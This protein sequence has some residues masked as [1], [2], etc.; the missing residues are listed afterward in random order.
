M[1]YILLTKSYKSVILT[2]V[3][4]PSFSGM[5]LYILSL[6][7]GITLLRFFVGPSFAQTTT[8]QPIYGGGQT[9][10]ES[11]DLLVDKKIK[12]PTQAGQF[13]DNL[14]GDSPRYGLDQEII[15]NIDVKNTGNNTIK[16]ITVQDV[17]P[18]QY[19]V[20]TDRIGKF[21]HKTKLFTYTIAELKKDE[22]KRVSIKARSVKAEQFPWGENVVCLVNQALTFTSRTKNNPS[23]DNS[24]FC[25]QRQGPTRQEVIPSPTIPPQTKGGLPVAPQ[26][27]T[28]TT[29]KSGPEMLSLMALIPAGIGGFLLRRKTR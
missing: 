22:T 20:F 29:P 1:D 6:A 24:R 21:D 23:Q 28:R 9:C 12:H 5:K 13:V 18:P 25:I 17:F 27:Q 2:L 10:V 3:V 14:V 15:F 26:P 11:G 19:V 8:C 7:T 4:L 16:D